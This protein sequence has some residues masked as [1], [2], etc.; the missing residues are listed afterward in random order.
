MKKKKKKKVVP[1][2][3]IAGGKLRKEHP[4]DYHYLPLTE[5]ELIEDLPEELQDAWVKLRDSASALGEQRIYT[6]AKAIMF[7][8]RV[9]YMFV[10]PKKKYLELTFFLKSKVKH[11]LVKRVE[12]PSKT[13]F[14]HIIHLIHE[15]QIDEPLTD[16]LKKAFELG[17]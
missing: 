16:W 12:T 2:L 10:R 15:D 5:R 8:R 13:K 4:D 11:S 9:C 17:R 6:S 3:A 7:A 14:S 1:S